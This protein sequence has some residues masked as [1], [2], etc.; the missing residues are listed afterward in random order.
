MARG[1]PGCQNARVTRRIDADRKR[2]GRL[3]VSVQFPSRLV[4]FALAGCAIAL[5][6]S[7]LLQSRPAVVLYAS[8]DQ[9]YAEPI[10]KEF[11]R[12]IGIRVRTVFDGEAAK[13]VAIAMRLMAERGH[14]R[15]DVYWGN[16]ELRTRQLAAG[17]VFRLTNGWAAFGYRSRRVALSVITSNPPPPRSLVELTNVAFR[18]RVA[19]A[20][21]MFGT[22]AT[23][24]LALRQHWGESNWLSW[25]GALAANQPFIVD[26]NSVAARFA[27]RGEVVAALTDSDD[28]AAEIREGGRLSALPITAETLLIPNT[29]A[30][31]RG[32]PNPGGAQRLFEFL[33]RPEIIARLVAV[34]ALEGISV[35]DVT[36][37][38]L[39]PDWDRMLRELEPATV[40]L[41][42]IFRR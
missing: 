23:H 30:V 33:Q 11:E 5:L 19:L 2:H 29:V 4:L 25:C 39:R 16:E 38:T 13:T 14:P 24:L 35:A 8:Q 10:L 40:A 31:I 17:G 27:A 37:P 41:Q 28:I 26:G 32:G 18:G 22:T 7:G 20:Y 15:C 12:E 6:F 1:D 36:T 3:G 42:R 9:V 34:R 21:P